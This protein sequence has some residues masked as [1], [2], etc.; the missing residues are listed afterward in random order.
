[1]TNTGVCN[2]SARSN[3]SLAMLKHS[4]TLDGISMGWRVSPCDK[5]ATKAMSPCEV[6]V[7]KPVEG[8]TR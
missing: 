5:R 2:C 3:A 6:R 7:G 8:P 1:M 4:L